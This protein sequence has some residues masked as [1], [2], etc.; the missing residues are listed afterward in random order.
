MGG[1]GA[2]ASLHMIIIEEAEEDNCCIKRVEFES[3]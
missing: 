3:K 1:R 2:F